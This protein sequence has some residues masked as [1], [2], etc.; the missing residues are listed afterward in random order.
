[1]P[2]TAGAGRLDDLP[3]QGDFQRVAVAVEV[4]ALA[5]VVGNAVARVEF[6]AARDTHGVHRS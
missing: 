5:G 4:A 1:M 6:Q 3:G 2:F